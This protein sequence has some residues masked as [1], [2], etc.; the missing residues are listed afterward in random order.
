MWPDLPRPSCHRLPAQNPL[1]GNSRP[2]SQEPPRRTHNANRRPPRRGNALAQ[3]CRHSSQLR[4]AVHAAGNFA[5]VV[6]Q[7]NNTIVIPA[8]GDRGFVVAGAANG[9][10]FLFA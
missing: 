7:L 9:H 4:P 3:R 6:N 2:A 8:R 1:D 5:F 10:F